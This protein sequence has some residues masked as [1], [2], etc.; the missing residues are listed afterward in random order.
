MTEHALIYAIHRT[1]NWW[2][3]VGDHLGFAAT[4]LTDRRGEGDRWVTDDFYRA[5]RRLYRR[6]AESSDLLEPDEIK[7]VIARCRALRWLP[8]RKAKAM[9]L[10]M[11]EAMESAL[12]EIRPTVVISFTIDSYVS[13]VLCRRAAARGIEHYELTSSALPDL[14]MVARRG[15]LCTLSAAPDPELLEAKVHEMVDPLYKPTIFP[16]PPTFTA[17]R[18]L[19]ILTYFRV[20]AAFFK[21][22][23]WYRRDRLNLH[24]LDAQPV[25]GH[26]PR[27]SDVGIVRRID[28]DWRERMERFPKERRVLFP[29]QLFP[30][31]SIDYWVPDLGLVE[32]EDLLVEAASAFAAHGLHVMVKDHPLQ[33]GFRQVELIDRLRQL[34]NLSVIP[35]EVSSNDLLGM[36]GACFTTT[37]TPGLQSAILGLKSI[38]TPNYYTTGDEDFVLLRSRA[39]TPTLPGRI[40]KMPDPTAETLAARHRRIVSKLLRGS[41]DAD[42][43]SFQKFDPANP[44]P[45]AAELG[46]ALGAQVL[47]LEQERKSVEESSMRNAA[48]ADDLQRGQ[49][50]D[51]EVEDEG[52]AA[53]IFRL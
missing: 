7:E 10:A 32:Y 6:S 16:P 12:D 33:F 19:R 38:A 20:R 25:L 5:Y 13:D 3:F 14:C 2:R 35:Y 42:I 46:C 8:P 31:A 17:L 52:S 22:Y 39:E 28:R 50:Q 48:P 45:R 53:E 9:A 40:L 49:P 34:P 1:H 51:I 27:Y 26:K 24:Y 11:A 23:A 37:G 43:L 29:L 4:V 36:V 18:F 21:A 47:K 15:V 30:E 41:F 44:N